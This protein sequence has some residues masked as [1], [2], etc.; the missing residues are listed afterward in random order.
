[1]S[2]RADLVAQL[3]VILQLS[4]RCLVIST[5]HRG[6]AQAFLGTHQGVMR[7]H[8]ENTDQHPVVVTWL[9]D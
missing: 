6:D 7:H 2:Q 4:L 9:L 1:M 8:G 3:V 5:D